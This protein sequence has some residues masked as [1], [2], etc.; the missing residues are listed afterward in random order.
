MK[1]VKSMDWILYDTDL[2]NKKF[3]DQSCH[4]RETNQLICAA[5][6]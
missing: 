4:N 3:K 2:C 5:V 1:E 6:G